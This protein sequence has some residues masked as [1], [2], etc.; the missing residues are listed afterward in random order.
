MT[1]IDWNLLQP[2][3]VGGRFQ[4]GYQNALLQREH[5]QELAVQQEERQRASQLRNALSGSLNPQTGAI[6]YDAARRAYI[7][8]G[9]IQG[10]IG[11]D[12]ARQAQTQRQRG[13]HDDNIIRGSRVVQQ[14]NPTDDASWQRTLAA[15]HDAGVD[16]TDVPQHFD[17]NYVQ[18]LH[19]AARALADPSQGYTLGEGDVRY[20]VNGNVVG[21]GSPPRPRYYSVPQGGSL[22]S[23]ELLQGAGSSPPATP[24]AVGAVEGGYRFRGGNPADPASWEP[25]GAAPTGSA[26][27]TNWNNAGRPGPSGPGTFR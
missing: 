18:Q 12:T 3:D 17:P 7:G 9:D 5:Q 2:V 23:P 13:V 20:D 11:V 27:L 15:A 4:Q 8:A 10:A 6:D 22:Q 26:D 14:M 21:R 24:P 16:I 19:A 25:L 1:Q